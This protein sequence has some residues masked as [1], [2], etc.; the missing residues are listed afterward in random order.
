MWGQSGD[1]TW[2]GK[3]ENS[4]DLGWGAGTQEKV[5][6]DHKHEAQEVGWGDDADDGTLGWIGE[7]SETL[8]I[9][10]LEE[11]RKAAAVAIAIPVTTWDGNNATTLDTI[12]SDKVSEDGQAHAIDAFW[13]GG[14]AI[15]DGWGS[16]G[17]IIQSEKMDD[18]D[19]TVEA[20]TR[21]QAVQRGRKARQH[22]ASLQQSTKLLQEEK[23]RADAVTRIQ[24]IQRGSKAR[25]HTAALR[26]SKLLQDERE[27]SAAKKL[28]AL[29]RG[30][31]TRR[32]V[33]SLKRDR[34]VRDHASKKLQAIQRGRAVR[35]SM[36]V[37]REKESI[38]KVVDKGR[39]I[40]TSSV[41]TQLDDSDDYLPLPPL[42]LHAFLLNNGINPGNLGIYQQT[43]PP[44]TERST[45][46]QPPRK[47]RDHGQLSGDVGNDRSANSRISLKREY[48]FKIES[49]DYKSASVMPTK[50][51][52]KNRAGNCNTGEGSLEKTVK[53]TIDHA[54]DSLK[55]QTPGVMVTKGCGTTTEA[56]LEEA[57]T[58]AA[59]RVFA[60]LKDKIIEEVRQHLSEALAVEIKTSASVNRAQAQRLPRLPAQYSQASPQA[61]EKNRYKPKA[62]TFDEYSRGRS[63]LS[64][65]M[66]VIS[67]P[68]MSRGLVR[69]PSGTMRH[70]FLRKSQRHFEIEGNGRGSFYDSDRRY[71]KRRIES[72]A[73]RVKT[74][75]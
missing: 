67:P 18:E 69:S 58:I 31:R 57:V 33:S 66:A 26:S 27:H 54:L 60:N 20:I 36:K 13:E 38:P 62:K 56:P 72:M 8:I 41:K 48:G 32:R 68:S 42:P 25:R 19:F 17:G 49:K 52:V 37:M 2:G 15:D 46:S 61:Q 40:T 50:R 12:Q 29:E 11:E 55:E 1:A 3:D 24:A 30:K 21:I 59:E 44:V 28:Q 63:N 70:K 73:R 16:S 75:L 74:S 22:A 9:S 71:E 43:K 51:V 53:D 64:S 47:V 34:A 14:K 6:A 39:S 35:R 4:D 23:S 45:S 5:D 7:D 10:A 65:Q